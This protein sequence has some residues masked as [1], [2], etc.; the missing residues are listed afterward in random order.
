MTDNKIFTFKD[1]TEDGNS[2]PVYFFDGEKIYCFNCF[3][4]EE[5]A[6]LTVIMLNLF[7]IHWDCEEALVERR[8]YESMLSM[9]YRALS[10]N[11]EMLKQAILHEQSVIECNFKSRRLLEEDLSN[12]Y[13]RS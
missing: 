12:I 1:L 10:P 2:L 8:D 11:L 3:N 6:G 7:G 4:R 13:P 9:K 5:R